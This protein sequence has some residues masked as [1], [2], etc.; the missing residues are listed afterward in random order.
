MKYF[1]K[2]F[3]FSLLLILIGVAIYLFVFTELKSFLDYQYL[4]N[5]VGDNTTQAILVFMAL[6]VFM[7]GFLFVPRTVFVIASGLAFQFPLS[8]LVIYLSIVISSVVAYSIAR[9]LG[10]D[11]YRHKVRDKDHEK[12]ETIVEKYGFPGM[13]ILR[14]FPILPFPVVNTGCGITR[15]KFKT[16]FLGTCLGIIPDIL[17]YT[18]F[19]DKV[20]EGEI[21][22][23]STVLVGFAIVILF[24]IPFGFRKY[25]NKSKSTK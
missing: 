24:L 25:K 15:V 9:Y 17:L 18:A 7:T 22:A 16:Y 3:K 10:H 20:V 13:V 14:M 11:L 4:V 6:A 8:A 21:G 5:F 1:V 23:F 12:I 19:V 2:H